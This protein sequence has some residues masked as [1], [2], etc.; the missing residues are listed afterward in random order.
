MKIANSK[1]PIRDRVALAL[2]NRGEKRIEQHASASRAFVFT[3][4]FAG[5]RGASGELLPVEPGKF[6]LLSKYNGG[7]L[8]IGRSWTNSR[9]V[10]D[11][12][13]AQLL[14]ECPDV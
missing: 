4:Q 8:R 5:Q 14:R 1:L 6:W 3:R 10:S 9:P 7:A 11:E 13:K 12:V 2:I